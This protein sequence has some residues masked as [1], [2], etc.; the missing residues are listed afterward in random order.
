MESNA[1]TTGG[2]FG[3]RSREGALRGNEDVEDLRRPDLRLECN[4]ESE[5]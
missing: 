3:D 5:I 2:I 1:I 4:V